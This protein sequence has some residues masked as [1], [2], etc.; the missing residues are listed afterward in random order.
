MKL[1]GKDTLEILHDV[2]LKGTVIDSGIPAMKLSRV[3]DKE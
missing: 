3:P 2:K 1:P